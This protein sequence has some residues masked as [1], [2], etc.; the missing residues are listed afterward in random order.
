MLPCLARFL[1][2]S[3]SWKQ[4]GSKQGVF[5]LV[6][7]KV[8]VPSTFMYHPPPENKADTEDSLSLWHPIVSTPPRGETTLSSEAGWGTFSVVD[9]P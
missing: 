3:L 9:A 2:S 4:P 8:C 7:L 5:R 6:S 1:G